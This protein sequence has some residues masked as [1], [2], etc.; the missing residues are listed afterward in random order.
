VSDGEP[1]ETPVQ[2][3]LCPPPTDPTPSYEPVFAQ[4]ET[5]DELS[6]HWHVTQ[7]SPNPETEET[8][9]RVS[10]SANVH[11]GHNIFFEID[12]DEVESPAHESL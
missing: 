7:L 10:E 8:V 1:F 12:P 11:V 2:D 5:S 9:E 6:V 3:E 4:V